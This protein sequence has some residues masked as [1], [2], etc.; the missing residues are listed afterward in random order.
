MESMEHFVSAISRELGV[1]EENTGA[2]TAGLLEA[3]REQSAEK[4]FAV[5][6]KA[7]PGGE[8]LL[9]AQTA[10]A[11]KKNQHGVPGAWGW[12]RGWAG[13]TSGDVAFLVA[14]SKVGFSEEKAVKF[15][16]A[17][18]QFAA[19]HAGSDAVQ[20]VFSEAPD[21]EILAQQGRT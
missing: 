13:G 18:K 11:V 1:T 9:H 16:S 20:K 21:L 17:F 5:L 6:L 10:E 3:L 4:D 14:I 12:V 19:D 15:V 7:I 2:A 8:A